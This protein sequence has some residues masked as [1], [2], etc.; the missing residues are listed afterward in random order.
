MKGELFAGELR[1]A[2]ARKGI[3]QQELSGMT[4]VTAKSI[5]FYET[6]EALPNA[7]TLVALAD[8]LDTTPNDL[9]GYR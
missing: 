1:A 7:K 3:T 8:A 4:G 5:S 9:L 2:R 6:G